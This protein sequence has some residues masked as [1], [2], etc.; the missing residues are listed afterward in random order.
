[1]TKVISNP[2]IVSALQ[3]VAAANDGILLAESVVE[4]ARPARS[5]LHDQFDWEDTIAGQKWRVHQARQLINV[6]VQYLP[7][8]SKL[9]TKVFVSLSSDRVQGGY[10]ALVD[11]LSNKDARAMLLADAA[12]ELEACRKKYGHLQE[13]AEVFSVIRKAKLKRFVA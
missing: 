6:V 3:A 11:V 10:R 9:A 8:P 2:E 13:L 12:R 4:A 7:G 1:M 5:P